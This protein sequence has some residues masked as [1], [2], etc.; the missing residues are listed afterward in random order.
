MVSGTSRRRPNRRNSIEGRYIRRVGSR[1]VQTWQSI[2]EAEQ[3]AAQL[4]QRVE[5]LL[6]ASRPAR[7]RELVDIIAPTERFLTL[8]GPTHRLTLAF[9]RRLGV[10]LDPPTY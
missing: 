10:L 1:R 7:E 8:L 4:V 6:R 3:A 5:P 9:Y 2:E